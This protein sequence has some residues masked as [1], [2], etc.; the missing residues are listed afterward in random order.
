MRRIYL[1]RHGRPDLPER[2]KWCL[3]RTDSGLGVIGRMQA[4]ILGSVMQ[5]VKLHAVF[6]SPLSRSMQTAAYI[7]S[8]PIPLSGLREQD[9]GQWD[10]LSFAQIREEWPRLYEARGTDR[11]LLPPE[12]EPFEMARTRFLQAVQTALEQSEGDIALVTH[13]SVMGLFLGS[14]LDEDLQECCRHRFAYGSVTVLEYEEKPPQKGSAPWRL[15][16]ADQLPVPVLNEALCRRL[17]REAELPEEVIA[18]CALV[19]E[20]VRQ[21]CSELVASG[22]ELDAPLAVCSGWL[23]DLARTRPSHA[24]TAAH[25]LYQLGCAEAAEIVGQHHALLHPERLDE[26]AVVC[27]A[28]CCAEGSRQVTIAQRFAKS[29]EKCRSE[30]ALRAH[31]R[32]YEEVLFLKE[33]LNRQCGKEVVL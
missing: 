25:W 1:I 23:H 28:D 22:Y 17:L 3:G 5:D 9:F 14:I 10:G 6:C 24:Q 13:Q 32:R 7:S 15:S 16:R 26:A 8:A 30:D 31:R 2:E 12:A 21:F 4:C 33:Q 29:R 20:L 27:L 18:H 11:T 19:A